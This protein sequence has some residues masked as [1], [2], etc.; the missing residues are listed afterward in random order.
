MDIPKSPI[1]FSKY[2]NAIIGPDE[3]IMIPSNS[4]EVDYEAELAFVIGKKAKKVD[5]EN[6]MNYVAGYTT[7]ND[8]SA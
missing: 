3:D 1:M 6:A 7:M 8:V 5:Q 2:N 4:R